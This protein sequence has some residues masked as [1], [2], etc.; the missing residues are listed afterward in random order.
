MSDTTP[1]PADLARELIRHWERSPLGSTGREWLMY[2]SAALAH[3]RTIAEA[4]LAA[5]AVIAKHALCHD[6][7][8]KVGRDEFE[9]G[10]RRETVKEF[11]SCGW[12]DK[13]AAAEARVAEL[14]VHLQ[15]EREMHNAWRKR[16]EEAEAKPAGILGLVPGMRPV[17]PADLAEYERDMQ[18]AIDELVLEQKRKWW[19]TDSGWGKGTP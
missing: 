12:A 6:L 18:Q 19:G 11:G 16:A 14:E 9:E 4:L 15:T 1:T 17:N 2:K 7:H 8:G 13:L 10:C 5:E 3:G